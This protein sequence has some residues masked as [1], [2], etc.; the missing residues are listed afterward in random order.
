M[1]KDA[2]AVARFVATDIS[3]FNGAFST[4]REIDCSAV[5]CPAAFDGSFTIIT[6]VLDY[7]SSSVFDLEYVSVLVLAGPVPVDGMSCEID[8]DALPLGDGEDHI[9]V[10]RFP[11]SIKFEH[12]NISAA[13]NVSCCIIDQPLEQRPVG[14]GDLALSV[15]VFYHSV[16]RIR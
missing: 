3:T 12:W 15:T 9:L 7:K 10:R 4:G 13:G 6:A 5:V 14:F 8:D 2:A 16:S 11:V 1:N